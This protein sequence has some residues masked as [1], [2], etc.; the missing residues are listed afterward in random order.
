MKGMWMMNR[1]AAL[2]ATALLVA[3]GTD[4]SLTTAVTPAAAVLDMADAET[5]GAGSEAEVL[6][7]SGIVYRGDPTDDHGAMFS[8]STSA[9]MPLVRVAVTDSA[10]FV[11]MATGSGRVFLGGTGGWTMTDRSNGVTLLSG[12]GNRV[13][14]KLAAQ[15]ETHYRLQVTCGSRAA[16][17]AWK[18]AAEAKGHPT[19]LETI[20]ACTRLLIGRFPPTASFP[21][22]NNYR[23]LLVSQ[24]L[25]PTGAFWRH[26]TLAASYRI[27]NG[28]EDLVSLNP[29]QVQAAAGSLVTIGTSSTQFRRY[30]G[31]AYATVTGKG[32]MAGVNEL[33]MEQYIYGV[34]PRELGPIAYPEYEAQKAQAVAARTYALRGLG[35]RNSD[36]YDLRSTTADQVYGGL[37]DEHPVSRSAIDETAGLVARYNGAL[38]ET[39]YSSASG[40]HTS[41]NEEVFNSAPVPYLRGVPDAQRG[42]AFEHVPTLEIFRAHANP[43]SLR[44]TAEN[45]FES[46]WSTRERWTFEWTQEEIASIVASYAGRPVGRVH[47]LNVSSRGPSG[48]ALVIEYVTDSGTFTDTK[49]RIRSSLRYVNASGG[50]SN[51]PSTLIFLEPIRERGTLTGGFRVF[52]GGFGHGIGMSQTGAV[53]M[54]QKGRTYEEILRHYYQGIQLS[55]AY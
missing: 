29:V 10:N 47:A 39:L 45:I 30:R 20:P 32:T 22:R 24:G 49:D 55:A 1:A 25:A 9:A 43:T 46:D 23:L 3:C 16:V 34:V 41:N 38:I 28:L 19:F 54:A 15:A 8:I 17:E 14:V 51:L 36:G 27:V 53:G 13:E 35:R 2:A 6:F 11:P 4:S 7:P 21:V 42:K 33:P 50:R 40:G 37:Q 48:R 12:N 18:A 26:I 44:N 52:G 5:D 31:V